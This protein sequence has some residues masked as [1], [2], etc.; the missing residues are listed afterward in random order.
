LV[1]TSFMEIPA[2]VAVTGNTLLKQ[3]LLV[4]LFPFILGFSEFFVKLFDL[5]ALKDP[6]VVV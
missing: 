2:L 4:L 3:V 6:A 5:F 1:I